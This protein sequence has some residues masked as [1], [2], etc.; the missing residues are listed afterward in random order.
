MAVRKRDFG[1]GVVA[2]AAITSAA[3]K[4]VPGMVKNAKY[5]KALK[6]PMGQIG[7]AHV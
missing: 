5:A 7:R 2:G 1:A 3:Q 4:T 6:G